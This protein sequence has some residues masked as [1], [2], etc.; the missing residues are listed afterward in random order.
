MSS[1]LGTY[2]RLHMH[3]SIWRARRRR[4]VASTSECAVVLKWINRWANY[5]LVAIREKREEIKSPN[6]VFIR[7][8]ETLYRVRTRAGDASMTSGRS[9]YGRRLN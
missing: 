5:L 7:T 8:D 1:Y 9:T 2:V 3:V 4:V 6:L